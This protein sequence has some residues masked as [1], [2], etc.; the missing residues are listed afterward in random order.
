MTAFVTTSAGWSRNSSKQV[1]KKF[2]CEILAHLKTTYIYISNVLE[3]YI[4]REL[5]PPTCKF[6][7]HSIQQSCPLLNGEKLD[8]AAPVKRCNNKT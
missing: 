5:G 6:C 4:Y 7:S 3:F 2:S 8:K 1:G